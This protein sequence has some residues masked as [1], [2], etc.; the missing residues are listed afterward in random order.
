MGAVANFVE[1]ATSTAGEGD[2]HLEKLS[3]LHSVATGFSSLIFDTKPNMGFTELNDKC[4]S[5]WKALEEN[6][7][8]P[9]YLVILF[10]C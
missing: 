5:L 9:E 1:V 6:P 3:L 7:N 8:L 2:F 4:N 10:Q